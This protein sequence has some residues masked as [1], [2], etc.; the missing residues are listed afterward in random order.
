M[1]LNEWSVYK[2]F[3]SLRGGNPHHEAILMTGFSNGAYTCVHNASYDAPVTDL[4]RADF[5][6]VQ[7]LCRMDRGRKSCEPNQ[8]CK[9]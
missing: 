1:D 2:V 5:K 9:D 6:D 3:V 8:V 7:E 4:R